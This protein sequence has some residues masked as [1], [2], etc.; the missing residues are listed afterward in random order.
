[1]ASITVIVPDELAAWADE[2]VEQR[3]AAR[4]KPQGPTPAQQQE[5]VKIA[6]QSGTVA[7][8]Q[9]LRSLRP[10]DQRASR[11]SVFLDL[12]ERGHAQLLLEEAQAAEAAAT[13]KR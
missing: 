3:R 6:K 11:M 7:A 5:A 9:Y 8:N 10:R 13:K 2:R 12:I 4:A 1:M